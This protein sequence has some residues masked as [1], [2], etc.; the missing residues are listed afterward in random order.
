MP[1]A[2][3]ERPVCVPSPASRPLSSFPL[4]RPFQPYIQLPS[5]IRESQRVSLTC[6]LNFTCFGYDISL[7]WS[8]DGSEVSPVTSS[9]TSS[10][11]NVYTESKLTFQPKWTDHGKSMMCQVWHF[12]QVLSE[13]TVRLDVKCESLGGKDATCHLLPKS[14]RVAP[15]VGK[16]YVSCGSPVSGG[17][18]GSP[19]SLFCQ[20]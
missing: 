12:S 13:R 6:G 14:C 3:G 18:S 17:G 8:L 1:E 11:E 10:V 15:R 19:Y 16:A 20:S 5:E 7:R 4:E 9:I 2:R